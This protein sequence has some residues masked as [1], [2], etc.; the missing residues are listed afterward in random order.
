MSKTLVL[1]QGWMR[2]SLIEFRRYLF[3]SVSS[4][5]MLYGFFLMLFLGAKVFGGGRSGFGDTLAAV[6]V[7]FAVWTI[8]IMALGTLT[9]EVTQ[10]AQLGTLEQLGMSPF[11]LVNALLAR[12]LTMLTIYFGMMVV[13]LVSMM[14]TTGRWLNLEPLSTLPILAFTT[15]GVVGLGFFLGGVAIVFKRTQQAM[16][17][18]QIAVLGFIAAPVTRVPFMKYLPLTW[19]STLL[20]RVMVDGESI[21]SMRLED[22]LFLIGNSV[23]YFALGIFVFKRF[24]RVARERGLLG[25]Y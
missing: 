23:F 25:H 2:R 10:E 8:T 15:L 21:A 4:I 7:S 14:A 12:C 1:Y 24:E 3:D 17:V 22:I 11:G 6:V 16:Q 18:S 5:V 9:Q 20:R 13:L 19:G